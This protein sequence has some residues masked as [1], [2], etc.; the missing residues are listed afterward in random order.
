MVTISLGIVR[1]K[2]L[3]VLI[4]TEG[5]G[6]FGAFSSVAT[7]VSSI[8]GMGI[9]TSGVRQI[10]EAVG[11]ND[12][13]KIARTARVLR[14]V[15]LVM[16]LLGMATLLLLSQPISQA[17][18]GSTAYAG[19]LALLS[20]T[21]LFAAVSEGQMALI[22]G[23]RRIRDLATL[24]VIGAVLGTLFS[25]PIIYLFR[26]HGIV[27]FLICIAALTI[28]SSWW[29]AR[30][31][32]LETV[33]LPWSAVWSE[34]RAL[35]GMGVVFM[36]A[37]VV[38]NAVAYLIRMTVIREISLDAAGLYQAAWSL[39]GIY[40]GIVLGA[41]GSDY[42]PRLTAVAKDNVAANRLVNE[43]TEAALLMAVPGILGTLT[44]APWV[45][46]L[47]YA[48]QF[49]PAG[50][51]LRWQVLGLLGRIISWPIGFV[52]LA[53]GRTLVWFSAELV[54]SLAQ[55][56]MVWVG[57]RWFGLN[58][59]GMAFFGTYVLYVPLIALIVRRESGFRWTPTNRHLI[60]VSL[61][62]AGIVFL[63][64]AGYLPEPWGMV[65][66]STLTGLFGIYSLQRLAARAGYSGLRAAWTELQILV[67]RKLD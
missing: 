9:K 28:A 57:M 38:N 34:A 67:K 63:V 56:L 17:T 23:M 6:L 55:L 42:Y 19:A 30:K 41:M 11:T 10:A 22:Q 29:F 5:M 35:L 53:K 15:S 25:I 40:V 26:E 36:S 45:I 61:L 21:V 14:R 1:T 3:A 46:H 51:I 37:S 64:S 48:A 65:L 43:Q 44:F 47:F 27:P 32:T 2:V 33:S 49:E 62:V 50:D 24:S 7:L 20:V 54:T 52:L 16:G 8:A 59:V 31:I 39:A 13:Q 4:G 18:F 60:I 66:G 12:Q 58:G